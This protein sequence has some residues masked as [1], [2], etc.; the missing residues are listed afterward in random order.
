MAKFFEEVT[1]LGQKFAMNA[2][3]TVAQAAKDSGAEIT[4]FVR[5]AVGEGIEKEKE[6]FAAEVAKTRGG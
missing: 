3:I 5:M 2:D 6:D 4:G 1:L